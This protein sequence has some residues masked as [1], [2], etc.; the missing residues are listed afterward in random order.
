MKKFMQK[1]LPKAPN[2]VNRV[3]PRCSEN[4]FASVLNDLLSLYDNISRPFY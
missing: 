4:P 1:D 2:F 3:S